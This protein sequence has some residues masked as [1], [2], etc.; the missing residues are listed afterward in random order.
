MISL[1]S[2]PSCLNRTDHTSI[3]N[4]LIHFHSFNP[5]D[6]T[7]TIQ[8]ASLLWNIFV[9]SRERRS[10]YHAD[11]SKRRLSAMFCTSVRRDPVQ[12]GL[13][14]LVFYSLA[15]PSFTNTPCT[16]FH[17]HQNIRPHRPA[18]GS[19]VIIDFPRWSNDGLFHPWNF[20]S[21]LESRRFLFEISA[22]R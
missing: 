7:T 3:S 16:I 5:L 4:K 22:D 12:E 2:I 18:R 15:P 9:V 19:S 21:H 17:E 8:N 13:I 10:M 6:K 14:D 1:S 11:A 20:P